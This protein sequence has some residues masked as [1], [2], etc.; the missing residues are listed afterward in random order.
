[1][2]LLQ[3][4]VGIDIEEIIRFSKITTSDHHLL[5]KIYTSSEVNYCFS[6]KD[7]S[8]H[9]AGRFAAKEAIIK[10]GKKIGLNLFF[11]D[12]EIK[13]GEN[14]QPSAIIKKMPLLDIDVSISHDQTQAVAVA[15]IV[16]Q[17]EYES[18]SNPKN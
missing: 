11:S 12:I 5:K 7:P 1:M 2:K 14:H 3:I 10:A 16:C 17:G 13:P 6:K 18:K 4:K 15:V 9:L 8:P